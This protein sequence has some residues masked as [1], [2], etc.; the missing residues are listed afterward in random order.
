MHLSLPKQF[1]LF[2]LAS[3]VCW[4]LQCLISTLTQG[5]GGGHLFRLTCSVVLWGGR[6]T[7]NKCPWCVWG[8]LAVSLP[9]WV[10]PR[11]RR[12][13][14]PGL[15]CSGSRLLCREQALGYMHFASLSCSGSGSRVLHKGTDSVGPAF[16]A[17]PRSE[18]LRRFASAVTPGA[19]SCITS[20]SQPLGFLGGSGRARLRCAVC[21]LWGAELWL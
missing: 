1:P 4:S 14:F 3:S 5:G 13:C 16:C 12:V 11:S 18:Q 2:I 15:H 7:A 10:C 20:P 19:G 9:H 17:L 8:V 21:L 6:G